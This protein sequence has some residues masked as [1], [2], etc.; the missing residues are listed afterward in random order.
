MTQLILSLSVAFLLPAVPQTPGNFV[1]RP[2]AFTVTTDVVN[3]GVQPFTVTMPAFGN[4]LNRESNDGFEPLNFRSQM[5]AGEDSA[6]RIIPA[7]KNS[8]TGYNS[9]GSGYLDGGRARVYRIV[10]G[11]MTLVRT[12]NIPTGGTVITD[13]NVDTSKVIDPKTFEGF[14]GWDDW[15]RPGTTDWFTVFSVDNAG[16]IRAGGTVS[17]KRP[18]GKHQGMPPQKNLRTDF[19]AD[20]KLPDESAPAAPLNVKAEL[21]PENLVRLTWEAPEDP[22]VAG[23]ILAQ[24]DV[25]PSGQRGV[26]IQLADKPD[27]RD[28]W[29]KKGDMIIVEK[30]IRVF[31]RK[32]ISNRLGNLERISGQFY[33]GNVPNNFFPNEIPGK[34]WT[35][36][37]HAKN[38]PVNEPGRTYLDMTLRQGDTEKIGKS[39]IPDISTTKQD[40]YPVPKSVEYK[41]EV[42]MKADRTDAP[43]VTFEFDGDPKVG[44]FLA[45]FTLQPTM[46]WKKFEHTFMGKPSDEGAHAYF[47]L[48][49]KGPATYSVD[50]YRI[51]QNDA[52]YLGLTP[53]LTKKYKESGM[54]SMR[55]HGPIKTATATYSMDAF[56]NPGGVIQGI[57]NGNTLPQ[58]LAVMEKLKTTPWLQIEYHMSPEEWLGFV[59]FMAAPYDPAKDSPKTKPWA[60]K[61][62][63]Q[64]RKEP[65]TDAFGEIYFELSNETW[66]SLFA[67]WIFQ[68]M[69]DSASGKEIPRGEVYGKMQDFVT[70][71]FRSSPYWNEGLQK[72]L[73][74]VL[75]GWTIGSYNAEAVK[76]STSGEFISIAAYNGGWDEGEGTPK[77]EPASFFNVLSQSNTTA[78]HRAREQATLKVAT[79]KAGRTIR[80]GTYE[81]GPGYALNGLNN[82]KVNPAQARE[83]EEVMK[84]KVAGTATIDSFLTHAYHG[85]ELQNFFTF[86]EGDLWKSQAKWWRGG[87]F[88]PSFLSLMMFNNEAT[89]DLLRTET[90]SVS[91][92]DL[93]KIKRRNALPGAPLAA[94]FATRK[95]DRVSVF[96]INRQFPGYPDPA[97]DGYS[98][99]EVRLPF[100]K[101]RKITLHK[102]SGAPTDHNI[103]AELVK[104]QQSEIPISAVTSGKLVINEKTGGH[105]KGLPPAEVY[106]YVFEGTDIGSQGKIVPLEQ[107]LAQPVGFEAPR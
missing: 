90:I 32:V 58:Q 48:T 14:W 99:F 81:A 36:V 72:K 27:E 50:N 39:N 10:D 53:E 73:H 98:Q 26:F 40:Y 37:D 44:G 75:G 4:N 20:P 33:Q 100:T 31:D 88:Y 1:Q 94:V 76:G 93:P 97:V 3:V 51:Y 8:L 21:T 54:M 78:V 67:P 70:E 89:G 30:E 24:S 43:P 61:R 49:C 68:S 104:L 102:M 105:A 17:V 22:E 85:F 47:V 52:P 7:A 87:Q 60:A 71:I 25:N 106:L 91:T 11:K 86:A 18:D 5:F 77:V 64:G 107:T 29:I 56:T 95:G 28:K 23:Y 15:S 55:T 46:E 101:A 2:S 9:W 63:A 42:W 13:W 83:Q 38:T 62:H 92:V 79:A 34:T 66:N 6:D 80:L 69:P 41:M 16:N 65:W 57:P 19:K 103:E 59:E 96:C 74:I 45:P 82:D 84:S 12:A 35:I